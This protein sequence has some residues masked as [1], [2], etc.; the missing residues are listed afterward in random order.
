MAA[1]Q[2]AMATALTPISRIQAAAA[3]TATA[4]VIPAALT[5]TANEQ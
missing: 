5:A 2:P 1:T 4:T 3:S